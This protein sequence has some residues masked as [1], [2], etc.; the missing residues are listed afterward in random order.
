MKVFWTVYQMV[1]LKDI[2]ILTGPRKIQKV[3]MLYH[4]HI[5]HYIVGSLYQSKLLFELRCLRGF[6]LSLSVFLQ[7]KLSNG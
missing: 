7:K 3:Q 1:V 5:V 2:P 4:P 6:R